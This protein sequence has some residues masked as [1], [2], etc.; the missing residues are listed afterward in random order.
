ISSSFTRSKPPVQRFV[1]STSHSSSSLS[2]ST[3]ITTNKQNIRRLS[4]TSPS[5]SPS[6]LKQKP[7]SEP[8]QTSEILPDVQIS[9][10]DHEEEK[11]PVNEDTE[12]TEQTEQKILVEVQPPTPSIEPIN[13]DIITEIIN[14]TE[15]TPIS[16]KEQQI[17][18][19]QEYQRKLNQKIREA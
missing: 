8:L 9:T 15:P 17:I 4:G 14:P 18:E 16:K 7:K 13:I 12:E 3:T 5:P 19:E 1:M 11:L 6:P 2:P 10:K